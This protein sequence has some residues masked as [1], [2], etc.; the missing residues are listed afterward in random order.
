MTKIEET[1]ITAARQSFTGSK[2]SDSQFDESWM[3]AKIMHRGIHKSGSFREK[4]T[5]YSYAF[6]RGEKFDA[7]KGETII[8]N[9]FKA[10]YGETLNQVRENLK[11]REYN[12][13]LS[14]H[15][16][17][18]DHARMVEP[19]IREGKTMPFYRAYDQAGCALAAKLNITEVGAKSL[20][21]DTYSKN[22]GQEFY[23][24]GKALEKKFHEPVRAAE[25]QARQA[26]RT[27][28]RSQTRV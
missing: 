19:L 1:R 7:M 18:L 10:R 4:L 13:G 2:L 23:A 11:T 27:N 20:M 17:A 25:Q 15:E 8:R 21:S 6:S 3:L 26:Q 12:I 24:T 28:T 22:E 14:G 9:Q 16:Q 5:D